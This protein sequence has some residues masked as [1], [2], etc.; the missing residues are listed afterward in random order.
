MSRSPLADTRAVDARALQ[1]LDV[2]V[3]EEGSKHDRGRALIVGGSRE[4]PGAMLLAANAAMRAGAGVVQVATAASAASSLGIAIPEARIIP[5]HEVGVSG[6]VT[7]D[8]N[9]VAGLAGHVDAVI[10]GPGTLDIA[11]TRSLLYAAVAGLGAETIL[12][13]DAAALDVVADDPL[14]LGPVA[15]RV[16]L[17][18]NEAARLTDRDPDDVIDD[19][20][21]V[22]DE[23]V[24]RFGTVVA[25]RGT[26]TWVSAPKEA[27][28][29]NTGGHRLLGVAGS[30]DVLGGVLLGFAARGYTPLAAT[31]SAVYAH[32]RAGE[33]LAAAGPAIGR[34][35]RELLD[36]LPAVVE[37]MAE[38]ARRT[39]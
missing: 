19:P 36:E 2:P 4:T 25:V 17:M 8:G 13:I 21:A 32:A 6:A 28:Y 10:V 12:I 26:Q 34:F 11:P 31:I 18:P 37:A 3:P 27:T 16:V 30:G 22:L 20:A 15:E 39:T 7:D 35:A 14:L 24:E 9:R 33:R 29:C 5:L 23:L 1:E 38:E